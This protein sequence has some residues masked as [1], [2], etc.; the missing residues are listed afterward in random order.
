MIAV[1]ASQTCMLWVG[2]WR[3][4][5]AYYEVINRLFT[6]SILPH[7]LLVWIHPSRS[8]FGMYLFFRWESSYG[9]L[10]MFVP[11]KDHVLWIFSAK[12]HVGIPIVSQYWLNYLLLRIDRKRTCY[13]KAIV[14]VHSWLHLGSG[15]C[16]RKLWSDTFL[17]SI[18]C[19]C[20]QQ[21]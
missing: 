17:S 12:A 3:E 21:T 8:F 1:G 2:C 20:F 9:S 6:I 18:A 14:S 15:T 4:P 11:S 16:T 10:H 5:K 7:N 19:N 13:L